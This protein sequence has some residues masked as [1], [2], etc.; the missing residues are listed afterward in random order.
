M[1]YDEEV[2]PKTT[3]MKEHYR[4]YQQGLTT[5]TEVHGIAFAEIDLNG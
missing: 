1:L 5:Q 3:D 2:D 4:A